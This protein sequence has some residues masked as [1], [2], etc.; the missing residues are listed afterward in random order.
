MF[1]DIII[2]TRLFLQ[3]AAVGG[4]TPSLLP[5][6]ISIVLT[7]ADEISHNIHREL[8]STVSTGRL[9]LDQTKDESGSLFWP[10]SQ[11]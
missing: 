2:L 3:A 1:F 9:S 11:H 5:V 6:F 10:P 8:D 4:S 7:V